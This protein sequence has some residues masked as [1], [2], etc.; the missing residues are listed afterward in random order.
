M[1]VAHEADVEVLPILGLFPPHAHPQF[2]S[3]TLALFYYALFITISCSNVGSLGHL[4][5]EIST[6]IFGFV[7]K[8]DS[9]F[10]FLSIITFQP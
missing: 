7:F 9:F 8:F 2:N 3:I 6:N 4:L 1:D 10:S 5:E